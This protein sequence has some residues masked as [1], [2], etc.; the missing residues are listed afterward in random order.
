MGFV[1][2]KENYINWKM[3]ISHQL[4]EIYA[5]DASFLKTLMEISFT[6]FSEI[7]EK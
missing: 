2:T 3:I 1:I 4:K 6:K 7:I 5:S